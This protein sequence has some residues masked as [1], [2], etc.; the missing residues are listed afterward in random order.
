MALAF[1]VL[2]NAGVAP[3]WVEANKEVN[4]LLA[5]RDAILKRAASGAGPSVFARKRDRQAL[6]DLVDSANKQ[7]F[8]ANTEAP[9]ASAYRRPLNLEEELARYES[10][11]Q[12]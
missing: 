4:E 11:C 1:H 7:I 3:P 12:R 10:A 2:K 6:T 9:T 5:K 8:K